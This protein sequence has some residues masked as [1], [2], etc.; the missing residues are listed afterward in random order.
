MSS[1]ANFSCLV[2]E[3]LEVSFRELLGLVQVIFRLS[4]RD[5]LGIVYRIIFYRQGVLWGLIEVI[6]GI[7][8]R[9]FRAHLEANFGLLFREILWGGDRR[10]GGY[11]G[12]RGLM[13][14]GLWVSLRGF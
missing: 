13:V 11:V 8:H 10:G 2:L 7:S 5:F 14:K 1:F 4:F 3:I 6:F 9:D 12:I